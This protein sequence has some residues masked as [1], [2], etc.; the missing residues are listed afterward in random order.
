MFKWLPSGKRL[1]QF[2]V[3]VAFIAILVALIIPVNT[4]WIDFFI[5]VSM[6]TA[7]LIVTLTM[8]IN[9]PLDFSS[10]PSMILFTTLFRL[11]VN[12]T[13]TRSILSLGE[14][15]KII[16]TFAHFVIG[17]NYVIGVVVFGIITIINFVVVTNGAQRIGEVAARFTL[18]ALPG[19]Q[20]SIDADLNAGIINEDQARARRKKLEMEA[21]Y[22]GAMDGASRFVQRD[23]LVSIILIFINI[24]A[25]LVVGI[26]QQGRT[27][28]ESLTLF[29]QLTIGDGL[30]AQ[31]PAILISTATGFMVTKSSDE[32]TMGESIIHQLT[33]VYQPLVISGGFVVLLGFIPGM[34]W[35]IMLPA[36]ISVMYLAWNMNKQKSKTPS[37]EELAAE[38][39]AM[40]QGEGLTAEQKAKESLA[41]LLQVDQLELE[42]GYGLIPLVDTEQHGDL[43]ER[44]T[45]IRKQIAMTL[46]FIMPPMRIRD[47]IT[48]KPGEYNIKIKGSVVAKGDLVLDRYLAMNPLGDDKTIEGTPTKEPAFGLEAYWIRPE[49][50]ARA[51]LAGF[52]VVDPATVLATHIT[53]VIKNNATDL[54]NRQAVTEMLDQIK[55]QYSSLV[56]DLIPAR[57]QISELQKVLQSLLKEK[58]SIRNLPVILETLADY[59]NVTKDY[60]LLTEYVR[61]SL[62]RQICSELIDDENNLVVAT[63]DPQIEV[64]ISQNLQQSPSGTIPVLPPP[65][66]RS[67]VDNIGRMIQTMTNQ[68][69]LPIFLVSPRIR[70]YFRKL[71]ERVY[72]G[73]S[74]LSYS[75]IT[76][77][78][79]LKTIGMVESPSGSS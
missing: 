28:M 3:P 78:V 4:Y 39:T 50:R 40:E 12:V 49:E 11:V 58:I 48:I 19:K 72:T 74:V 62:A 23:A 56:E 30:V 2:G 77:D 38:K 8:F 44:I 26:W 71:I 45:N 66:V 18:D 36:G 63:L 76:N 22:F 6:F 5:M 75:E 21:D 32:E 70:P 10:F 14:A 31:I 54:L 51:E 7:V 68:G 64:M 52:T 1:A 37:P 13:T 73:V 27:F 55:E 34:P 15:G 35:F 20:I 9:E 24:G 79:V 17:G 29:T 57:M 67:L 46:G 25:G 41:G 16:D 53:E 61:L 59:V 69:Y 47:N 65:Y 33:Q 42:I 60:E 43:L